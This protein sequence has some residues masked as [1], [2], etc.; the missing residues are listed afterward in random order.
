MAMHSG[1]WM[2][3]TSLFVLS[4]YG[5]GHKKGGRQRGARRELREIKEKV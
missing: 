1:L 5:S 2:A 4:G 3:G